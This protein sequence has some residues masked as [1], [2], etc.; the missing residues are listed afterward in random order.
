MYKCNIWCL[1]AVAAEMYKVQQ[2]WEDI[3]A[4]YFQKKIMVAVE[5]EGKLL[6]WAV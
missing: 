1:S 2:K 3:L 4:A 6:T 5:H